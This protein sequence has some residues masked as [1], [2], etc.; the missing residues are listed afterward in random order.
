MREGVVVERSSHDSDRPRL[1]SVIVQRRLQRNPGT[2]QESFP[3]PQASEVQEPREVIQVS[4][5]E[6]LTDVLIGD[7]FLLP[8]VNSVLDMLGVDDQILPPPESFPHTGTDLLMEDLLAGV[9]AAEMEM[10][11]DSGSVTE[12]LNGDPYCPVTGSQR[13]GILDRTP[14]QGTTLIVN[15]GTYLPDSLKQRDA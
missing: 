7:E 5:D 8:V 3:G 2:S 4:D 1:R 15:R 12:L 13:D 11:S 10:S 6:M 14:I 9:Q